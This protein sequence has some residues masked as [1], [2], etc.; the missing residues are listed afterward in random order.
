MMVA[1]EA[2]Q[3]QVI[4]RSRATMLASDDVVD[5]KRNWIS[6]LREAAVLTHVSRTVDN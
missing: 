6:T 3:G 5:F 1:R 4:G 2:R